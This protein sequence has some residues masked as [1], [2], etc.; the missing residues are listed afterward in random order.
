[1]PPWGATSEK[2]NPPPEGKQSTTSKDQLMVSLFGGFRDFAILIGKQSTTSKDQLMVSLF[3][4]FRDFAIL[5]GKQSTTSK[6]PLMVSLFGGFRDFA[7]LI[8]KQSTT[9]KAPLIV[10]L[11]GNFRDFS[12]LI[13][14][15]S[16]TSKD[17]LMVSLFGGFR[18]FSIL[19]EFVMFCSVS[20]L[21]RCDDQEFRLVR[22]LM[23]N[24]DSAVRPSLS[25]AQPVAVAFRLSLLALLA[26]DERQGV[27]STSCRITQIRSMRSFALITSNKKSGRLSRSSYTKATQSSRRCGVA[28]IMLH[29]EQILNFLSPRENLKVFK[30]P[31]DKRA[32]AVWSFLTPLK[33]Y[34]STRAFTTTP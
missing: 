25:V 9:S 29:F 27:V 18:D 26:M 6:D 4:G 1:M 24:Y 7:I 28:L 20:G 31:D 32:K 12:I 16:T 13:G 10:S 22:Y 21:V 34:S 2:V 30:C 11:F 33:T 5:I 19:I 15:Q 8:G 17:Q 14:K 23:S 3:G